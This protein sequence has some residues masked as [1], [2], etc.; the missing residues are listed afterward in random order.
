MGYLGLEVLMVTKKRLEAE[1]TAAQKLID[2]HSVGVYRGATA[3]ALTPE[4]AKRVRRFAAA[5][6]EV[7]GTRV[8]YQVAACV[9]IS[10]GLN[11]IDRTIVGEAVSRWAE[12]E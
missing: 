6:T 1:K 12:D 7:S 4:A 2:R 9:L 11:A 5:A 10:A 3:V 8:S